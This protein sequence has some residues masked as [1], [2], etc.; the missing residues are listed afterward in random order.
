ME[1]V[2]RASPQPRPDESSDL[3]NLS[4]TEQSTAASSRSGLQIEKDRPD[5]V[6]LC[7][8]SATI[9]E[10]AKL[11]EPASSLPR[12][13]NYNRIHGYLTPE[14]LD[15]SKPRIRYKRKHTEERQSP[16][17]RRPHSQNSK[18]ISPYSQKVQARASGDIRLRRRLEEQEDA[19]HRTSRTLREYLDKR[20]KDEMAECTFKPDLTPSRA[21]FRARCDKDPHFKLKFHERN[22]RMVAQRTLSPDI[23][24]SSPQLIRYDN[25]NCNFINDGSALDAYLQPNKLKVIK[26]ATR[27]KLD[28]PRALREEQLRTRRAQTARAVERSLSQKTRAYLD[29]DVVTRLHTNTPLYMQTRT[30]REHQKAMERLERIHGPHIQREVASRTGYRPRSAPGWDAMRVLAAQPAYTRAVCDD[31][32]AATHRPTRASSVG[33]DSS[34]STRLSQMSSLY[35]ARVRLSKRTSGAQ[36]PPLRVS[37]LDLPAPNS[38]LLQA[39]LR[40]EA[41][42]RKQQPDRKPYVIYSNTVPVPPCTTELSLTPELFQEDKQKDLALTD[43]LVQSTDA[44][45]GEA[46]CASTRICYR[47]PLLHGDLSPPARPHRA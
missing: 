22:D 29:S 15:T 44:G 1:T 9:E 10:I 41:R 28:L 24:S 30:Y 42:K 17:Q 23:H 7:D 36:S 16:S 37:A 27:Q 19:L 43:I 26:E 31:I 40:R 13:E 3:L 38:V 46:L 21:L 25:H 47:G 4:A 2:P 5:P 14:D 20:E 6:S 45:S 18:Y 34:F 32:I 39:A 8:V 35:R 12:P 11:Y 33:E